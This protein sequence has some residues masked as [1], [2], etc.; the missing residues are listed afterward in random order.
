M[1]T[2]GTSLEQQYRFKTTKEVENKSCASDWFTPIKPVSH[3]VSIWARD[4]I[5]IQ[6]PSDLSSD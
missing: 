3:L 1:E 5:P 4:L 2:K 6:K